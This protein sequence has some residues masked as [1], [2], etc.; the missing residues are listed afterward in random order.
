MKFLVMML[1]G[2]SLLYASVNINTA[3]K[4]EL[5]SLKG[6]GAKKAE[7]I[8]EYRSINCFKSIE[9]IANVKGIGEKFI[10]KNKDNINLSGCKH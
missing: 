1:V 10:I 8:L 2:L 6:I 7:A 9:E 3:D 5:M 4:D